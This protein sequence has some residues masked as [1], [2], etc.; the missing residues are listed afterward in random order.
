MANAI[1]NIV[2]GAFFN[3]GQS[4]CG[5]ERVYVDHSIFD[6]FVTGAAELAALYELGDPL[7]RSTTLGPMVHGRAADAVR[8]QISDA[9]D[10]GASSLVDS[11]AFERS[12]AGS[13]YLAPQ[14]LV[15]V[16]HSM[17]VMREE[18][19]GPVM[20]V[21]PVKSDK[22]AIELM[23]DSDF[24]LS[25][26][27]WTQDVDAVHAIGPRLETGTVFM[28]R[29]D[30]LDPGL[31]WTGVKDTGRGITLSALGYSS[32]TQAKSYHLRLP[33]SS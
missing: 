24:G 8:Q 5:I 30:Y 22:Q 19:F 32:L 13:P 9:V 27:I 12:V 28:N 21:M 4:C 15:G 2:D 7:D 11:A 25:A 16:S 14:V 23:N 10:A 31:A 29:A 26:S 17:S 20:G 33:M 3:S 1:E 18:S 6:E